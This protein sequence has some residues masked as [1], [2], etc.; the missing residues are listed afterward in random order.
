[1]EKKRLGVYFGTFAPFHKGHQQQIYK[2]AA[3]N[4]QVLLVVSGYT[5]DRGDKIGLPLSQ[6][7]QYLQEDFADEADINVAMLD[8]TDLPPMPQ[9]WDVWFTRLFGLLKKYQSQEITFYVGEPEYVT[10]LGARFPQDTRTYKVEMADRQDIKI[11]AT[12]IRENPLLHWNE[13]NPV[14]RRHFTKIV[15]IIGGRK[16]GKSTLARRLARSFNNAPFA[17][18]IEQAITSAGNQGIVFIDNTLSPDID[19]VLLIPSDNDAALLKKIAEQGLT[20]KVVRLD[21]EET[22]RDT[23]AYLGRYYHAI[24]AISQYTGIQIDR[25]KY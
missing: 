15:G 18:K 9:G 14:F 4:D 17:E 25:L 23:R 7:Y 3:L 24:D 22:I 1:M 11:S 16:S 5:D 21:D 20:E 19:L 6:R 13:I 2:C 10:E 12:E 8:E